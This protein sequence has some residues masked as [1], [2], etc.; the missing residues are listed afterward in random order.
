MSDIKKLGFTDDEPV[1]L[2]DGRVVRAKSSSRL[3]MLLIA[4]VPLFVW[5]AVAWKMATR[6]EAPTFPD[7]PWG[8]TVLIVCAMLAKDKPLD[9]LAEI[10]AA[11]K[12]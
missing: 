7:L 6:A 10:A 1:T 4:I 8:I 3:A 2:P 5:A 9:R 11:L 12:R